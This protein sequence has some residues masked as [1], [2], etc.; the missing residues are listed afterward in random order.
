MIKVICID[1]KHC[2]GSHS[3]TI[4]RIYDVYYTFDTGILLILND[5]NTLEE[6]MSL[7]FKPVD[8]FRQ[9]RLD[10]LGI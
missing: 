7:R 1:N 4:G 3:L 9:D 2:K 10:Q 8:E 6:H 5:S